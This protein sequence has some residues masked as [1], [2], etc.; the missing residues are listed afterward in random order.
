MGIARIPLQEPPGRRGGARAIAET[1]MSLDLEDV[2]VAGKLAVCELLA[3]FADELEGS[4]K[5]G[6]RQRAAD[7]IQQG[8]LALEGR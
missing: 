7:R 2:G 1:G 6:A 4:N 8:D 5:L 3:V